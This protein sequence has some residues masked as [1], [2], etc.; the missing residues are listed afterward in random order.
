MVFSLSNWYNVY[1]NIRTEKNVDEENWQNKMTDN[2][3]R[4][5]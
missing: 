3:D 1:I 2:A 5:S 4:E